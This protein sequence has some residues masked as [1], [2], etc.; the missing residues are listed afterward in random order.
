MQQTVKQVFVRHQAQVYLHQ[1]L[2][3]QQRL[4]QHLFEFN[5]FKCARRPTSTRLSISQQL[6]GQQRCNNL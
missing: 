4:L 2:K 1:R 5:R 6:S 3:N